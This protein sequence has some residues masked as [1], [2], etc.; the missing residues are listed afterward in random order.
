MKASVIISA[1]IFLAILAVPV[2]ASEL[3]L[4]SPH[5]MSNL[6][7]E[8]GC[9]YT[10]EVGVHNEGANQMHIKMS[11]EGSISS[12]TTFLPVEFDIDTDR[13]ERV[14]VSVAP[15]PEGIYDGVISATQM[16]PDS[17]G[18]GASMHTGISL[19]A[20]IKITAGEP[21]IPGENE[22]VPPDDDQPEENE[23][24]PPDDETP[25]ENDNTPADN[26]D[27]SSTS[28]PDPLMIAAVAMV[29]IACVVVFIVPWLGRRR[30]DGTVAT[31]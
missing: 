8:K 20:P 15:L 24:I 5:G 9:P 27:F 22:N 18:E 2:S 6:K 25:E 12:Y 21:S 4:T 26:D 17:T 10:F 14:T 11:A 1:A 28:G 16:I 29:G 3:A 30:E 19:S 13:S 31:H 23:N 7:I